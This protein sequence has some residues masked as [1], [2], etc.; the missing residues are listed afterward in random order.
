MPMILSVLSLLFV[1]AGAA[2]AQMPQIDRIE[3]TEYGIYTVDRAIEGRDALGINKAAASNVRHAATMRTI[4]AQI[5][6]TFGFRYKVIGRPYDAPVDLREVVIF[7]PSGLI[8]SP[9]SKLITH[10]EFALHTRIGQSSYA[11]YT[12]EDGFEL[13]PGT[14]VIEIW[15]GNRKLLTQ[16]FNVV[17]LNSDCEGETCAGL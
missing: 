17:P 13:V 6:T 16:S 1:T 9:S 3:V 2:Y 14:W 11:S 10:D 4:P 8:P 15:H 7:P 5:G 12:L